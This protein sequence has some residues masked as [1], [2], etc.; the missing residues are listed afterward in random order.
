MRTIRAP[1]NALNRRI[2]D[3]ER[4][5]AATRV[6]GSGAGFRVEVD[7]FQAFDRENLVKEVVGLANAQLEGPRHILFGVNPGG[8]NGNIVG[9]P[10][11]AIGDLKRAH[12]LISS[13]VE[14]LLDLAFIF[15]CI[16]GKLV[17]A[18]EIDG[19][20]FAQPDLFVF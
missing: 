6:S 1:G 7:P 16:N 13:L 14:P 4:T 19:C 12:R 5:V 2:T 10:N 8:M 15:D 3:A 11:D 20:E 9:I 17:G 18:L